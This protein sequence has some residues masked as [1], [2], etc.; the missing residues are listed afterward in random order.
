L[1]KASKREGEIF[2][3]LHPTILSWTA[4]PKIQFNGRI[5]L[6]SGID[7][8]GDV[9]ISTNGNEP[10]EEFAPKVF[11]RLGIARFEE[12]QD[13]GFV[14]GRY[15]RGCGVG[16]EVMVAIAGVPGFEG[17]RFGVGL[18]VETDDGPNGQYLQ[19]HAHTLARLFSENGWRCFVPDDLG[20]A[21]SENEG[22]VYDPRW[23]KR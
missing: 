10:L 23:P 17:Y 2:I 16:I 15:F 18:Q 20:T 3:E 21:G 7:M 11:S 12:R 8:A 19:E 1:R 9:L 5:E 4:Q 13:E 6:A 22:K 14:E